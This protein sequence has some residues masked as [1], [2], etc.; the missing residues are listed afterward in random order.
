MKSHLHLL[1]LIGFSAA[2]PNATQ[3]GKW[4]GTLRSSIVSN[5][6]SEQ[7]IGPTSVRTPFLLARCASPLVVTKTLFLAPG[8]AL[9]RV[10]PGAYQVVARKAGYLMVHFLDHR[11][12]DLAA[13]FG[14]ISRRP[15]MK[16]TEPQG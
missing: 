9:R 5:F 4:N 12:H 3:I 8:R 13:W 16:A 10:L 7:R 14:E 2:A 6:F 1:H 15:S 11:Q